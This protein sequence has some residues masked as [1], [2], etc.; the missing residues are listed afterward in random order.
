MK[1]QIRF[2]FI[3]GSYWYSLEDIASFLKEKNA[4]SNKFTFLFNFRKKLA[5]KISNDKL[6]H[7][8]FNYSICIKTFDEFINWV[9]VPMIIYVCSPKEID[10]IIKTNLIWAIDSNNLEF[11]KRTAP[12]IYECLTECI[13]KVEGK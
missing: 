5:G 2:T 12:E 7:W 10:K 1:T 6:S 13:F 9:N 8:N 4:I 3:E 11:M